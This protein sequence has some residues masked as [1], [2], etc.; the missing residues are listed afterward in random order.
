M[1]RVT[2]MLRLFNRTYTQRIGVLDESFLGTG[3]SLGASRLLFEIGE[4][5]AEVFEL[6]SR[7]GLDSGYVSRVLRQ[8]QEEGLI[9]IEPH[10]ADG[11][12]RVVS[13]TEH[14]LAERRRLDALSDRAASELIAPLST[15]QRD[16]LAAALETARRLLAAA[17][18]RFEMVDPQDASAQ[19]ALRSYFAELDA[20][21]STGFDWQANATG[22]GD[23]LAPPNGAFL[24]VRSDTDHIGCGGVQPHRDSVGEI[25]RMWI[26]PDW[27]GLGLAKRLLAELEAQ[28]RRLGYERAVLDTNAELVE[29]MALYEASGYEPIERYN[30]NPYAQR[31]YAKRL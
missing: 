17:T 10:E 22:D 2:Q 14:G 9:D 16:Q 24:L 27:R 3:R 19:S 31:W 25:K 5:G 7:L 15:R 23:A 4:R 8:L 18:V 12:R 13:L 21:F 20:R 11:R 6:R 26:H 30:D 1:E 29:A 28:A